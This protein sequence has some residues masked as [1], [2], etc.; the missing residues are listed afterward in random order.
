MTDAPQP[1][2]IAELKAAYGPSIK[3]RILALCVELAALPIP[4]RNETLDAIRAALHS[5]SPCATH[6]VDYIRWV[7]I[8]KVSANDYN[9]NSV[10]TVE[11]R[12]LHTSISHDGY[13]QPCVTVLD[14]SAEAHLPCGHISPVKGE[15]LEIW[16]RL[17]FN[18]SLH[19]PLDFSTGKE[20]SA[21]FTQNR[22]IKDGADTECK[23]PRPIQTTAETCASGCAIS[24][25]SGEFTT[26]TDCVPSQS[27]TSPGSM[28]SPYSWELA[29]PICASNDP[30]HKSCWTAFQEKGKTGEEFG[31]RVSCV[32]SE[33]AEQ[34]AAHHISQ[35]DSSEV[36]MPSEQSGMNSA[37]PGHRGTAEP[38]LR[39]ID[40]SRAIIVDGFHRYLTMRNNPEI[41]ATTGGL[42]PVVVISKSLADRMASTVRHNRARGTHSVTGMSTMVFALL[43][44]G[45]DDA[46]ICNELGM[47]PEELNRLKHITG[48]AVL[49]KDAEYSAAWI[50]RNQLNLAE[51]K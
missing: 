35:K 3:E 31:L 50:H 45:M 46:G 19:I 23:S 39:L 21:K 42:L 51:K 17:P 34:T 1:P 10:A 8:E 28:T 14:R 4:A 38:V 40:T 37:S 36:S 5:V 32:L 2:F 6:P 18:G 20:A 30:E 12:L 29:C 26:K 47:E 33:N 25:A 16:K 24:G 9:P 13:T 41:A 22:A 11:M 44:Q 43:E 27:G 49:F 48:F 7:P 15:H